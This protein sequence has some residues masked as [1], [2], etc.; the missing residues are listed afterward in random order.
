[1]IHPGFA[2]PVRDSQTVFRAILNAMALPGRIHAVTGPA[3][4]PP[5]LDRATAAVLLTLV[6]S[7]TPLWM[8]EQSRASREW[9][10]F[11]CGTSLVA[12]AEARFAVALKTPAL[13]G[14]SA[15][16]DED[17]EASATLIL[18]IASLGQGRP[19]RLTGPG[20]PAPT[21]L[22]LSGLNERF[23][24]EW[25]TNRCLF[26]RGLDLILCAG[27]RLAALP[28]TTQTELA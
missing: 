26:P 23:I 20:L 7:E 3:S 22:A 6:D 24:T 9:V 25:K 15:G 4:P 14:F 18:Q 1:M 21:V 12:A 19:F 5:P 28:R 16:A 27:D 13:G 11:H 10:A 17:P 2:D 8:D